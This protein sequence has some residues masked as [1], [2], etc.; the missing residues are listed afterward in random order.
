MKES[1]F[2]NKI[3]WFTF[4]YSVL[5]VWVHAYNS[6]LF[7][8]R[9]ETALTVYRIERI[10]GNSIAQIAVPGFFMISSYLF[11]RNFTWDKLWSK[12]N[13]R[14]RSILVPF[15]LWNTIYYLGYVIAS[16]LPFVAEVVGKEA[17]PF[18]IQTAAEAII[19]YTYNYVFW[20]MYQLILL[21]VLTPVIYL[22][23]KYFWMGILVL[24]GILWGIKSGASLPHLNLDALLYYCIAAF[25]A[26]HGKRIAQ[27][28]WDKK[29]GLSGVLILLGALALAGI[30]KTTSVVVT[31]MI[32]GLI[33]VALWLIVSERWLCPAKAWMKYNFFLYAVHFAFVRLINKTAAMMLPGYPALP[34]VF[35][36]LMPVIIVVISYWLGA[37]LRKYLPVVWHMLH[38]G[39]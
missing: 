5:V 7:L 38:G 9:T 15:I 19:H 25:A 31:V 35:Y 23:I 28:S 24:L 36:I 34:L 1:Q 12:W 18:G 20:Y 39:R 33:P 10:L 11:Y 4:I 16:R 37:F 22:G 8:G 26:L 29:T 30:Y 14:I 32:R 27:G 6:E 13:S 2:Y 3:Y 17:V 21:I